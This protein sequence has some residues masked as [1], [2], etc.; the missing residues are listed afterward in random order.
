ME[1]FEKAHV[2]KSTNSH[3]KDN[4]S[5]ENVKKQ[6]KQMLYGYRHNDNELIKNS[7]KEKNI[8]DDSSSVSGYSD[9]N[10][11]N[12]S[13]EIDITPEIESENHKEHVDQDSH[14]SDKSLDSIL[15]GVSEESLSSESISEYDEVLNSLSEEASDDKIEK[16][17]AND[18]NDD[19]SELSFIETSTDCDSQSDD[20]SDSDFDADGALA[21]KIME[22]LGNNKKQKSKTKSK[23]RKF[24]EVEEIDLDKVNLSKNKLKG[25][26]KPK[27]D[28]SDED[29]QM[30]TLSFDMSNISLP[31][32][33]HF[34]GPYR[35]KDQ[36]SSPS[37][38]ESLTDNS[39]QDESLLQDSRTQD[40][41]E[42]NAHSYK[43]PSPYVSVLA[44]NMD[45]QSLTDVLGEYRHPT[46]RNLPS[47][48][49][50]TFATNNSGLFE[51]ENSSIRPTVEPV[52]ESTFYDD[53]A[54]SEEIS[55]RE[56]STDS[57][58]PTLVNPVKVYYGK[59]NN[60][61]IIL[62]HPVE[63]YLHGKVIVKSLG[64]CIEVLGYTLQDDPCEVYAPNYNYA[65]YIKTVENQNAY[66]GLF[67]K[68]TSAGLLVSEAED[69]VTTLGEYDGVIC[70]QPLKS[71]QMDFVENNFSATDLFSKPSKNIDN[72]LKKASELLGC[73][74]YLSKPWKCFEEKP[75]W[76]QA[77]NAGLAP[78]SQSRGIVCGGKGV[79]K[80]TF[81]RYYVNRMLRARGPVLVIDLDPGQSEFTVAG[82]VSATVVTEP[83]LGPNF[84]HLKQP[85]LMLN[86]GM[87]NTMDNPRRYVAAIETLVAH[88]T[89]DNRLKNLPWIVNTMGMTN[90][91]GLKLIS[92]NILHIQPTFLLQID[93]KNVKK[94]YD[95]HLYAQTIKNLYFED[96][97][98]DNFFSNVKEVNLDYAFFLSHHTDNNTKNNFSLAPR[99]ERYLNFL[100]YFGS[101]LNMTSGNLLGIV[102][103]E[104]SMKDLKIG[105]NVKINQSAITKVINGK[106]VAL[107]QSP[108]DNEKVFTLSST[109][110]RCFGT[111]LIRGI[112]WEREVLYIITPVAAARLAAVDCLVYADWVPE[113]RGP[114]TA[115]SVAPGTPLPYRTAADYQQRQF[116]FAPKRR[117]NPL[118]L[119]KMSRNT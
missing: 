113:L 11:T 33:K 26:Y 111:G 88:C 49:Q 37:S 70:M 56:M 106:L 96:Y 59:N 60:C 38:I 43:P 104:V 20:E 54:Q 64:G 79:G 77:I 114:D 65:Q 118:Q 119:L 39:S 92:L 47:D 91:V 87:I 2:A 31:K 7:A 34:A 36:Q 80:S 90:T 102:P 48:S 30:E 45:S 71:R 81:L 24:E 105:L 93:S 109:P 61:I 100:A 66:Y 99:E 44:A 14:T 108:R 73:S 25:P 52:E 94:R 84:T 8:I 101:L 29:I 4:K 40:E 18:S 116:M 117:F 19:D 115:R 9:L 75:V 110:L 76:K 68:L 35:P 32:E 42:N 57:V 41:S 103:N 12:S 112:D 58:D 95:F 89:A 98:T 5:E 13:N 28:V 17:F 1:F 3:R 21:A 27:E 55:E 97:Q 15:E 6:L 107:C 50:N 23:K 22:K 85:E 67:G 51:V 63:I 83:L 53:T 69:I 78:D 86:I 62:K 82:N 16:M 74:L 10:I 46:V 72:C